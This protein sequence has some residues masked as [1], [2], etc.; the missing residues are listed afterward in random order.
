MINSETAAVL[1]YIRIIFF[2]W[3]LYLYYHIYF[4]PHLVLLLWWG[5]FYLIS[6]AYASVSK[7]GMNLRENKDLAKHLNTI[8]FHT[9]MVDSLEDLLNETSDLSI[10]WWASLNLNEYPTQKFI[11]W[12]NTD[13]SLGNQGSVFRRISKIFIM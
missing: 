7:G 12:R 5:A 6:Q 9:R 4:Y 2:I 1:I 3:N 11:F 13:K 10:Y 8:A